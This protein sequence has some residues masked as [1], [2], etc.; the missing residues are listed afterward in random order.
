M[1]IGRDTFKGIRRRIKVR[2]D[3]EPGPYD[4]FAPIHDDAILRGLSGTERDRFEAAVF[5]DEGGKRT[6]D[7]VYLRARLVSLCLVDDAGNRVYTDDQVT[8]LSDDYPS[9]VLQTLFSAAQKLNGLDAAAVEN[10]A[11]NS[12]GA[13]TGASPSA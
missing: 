8:E 3:Y 4:A 13:P 9:E 12:E 7:P 1:T 6:I 2:I 11:K 10:A 5:K